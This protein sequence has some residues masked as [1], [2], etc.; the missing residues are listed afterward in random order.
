[1]ADHCYGITALL[2]TVK[3]Y[4][5]F[6]TF[7]SPVSECCGDEFLL[8]HLNVIVLEMPKV[9]MLKQLTLIIGQT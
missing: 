7:L 6:N 2:E 4:F 9:K 5:I 3:G 8:N 1:M